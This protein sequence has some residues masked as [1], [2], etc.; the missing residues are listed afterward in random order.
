MESDWGSNLGKYLDIKIIDYIL[1][2]FDFYD[3]K[4]IMEVWFQLKEV[5]RLL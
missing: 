4:I 2:V 1:H 5:I 3:Y